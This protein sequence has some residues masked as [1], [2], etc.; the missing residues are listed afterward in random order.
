MAILIEEEKR[1]VNW[2]GI[3]TGL[4]VAAGLFGGVYYFFFTQPEKIDVLLPGSIKDIS[5]ISSSTKNFD[6]RSILDPN[7]GSRDAKVFSL[8]NNFATKLIYP[9]PGKTNPFKP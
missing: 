6:P 4:L 1:P 2:V 9:N 3:A 7:T 5:V 8:L